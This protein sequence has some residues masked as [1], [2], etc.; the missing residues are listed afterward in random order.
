MGQR[1]DLQALLI[2]TLGSSNVYFQPPPTVQMKYPCIIYKRSDV[3]TKFADNNP[4]SR[5][6]SYQ[7]TVI[8]SDP[9]SL[10]PDKVGMLPKCAFDRFFTADGLNHDVFNLYF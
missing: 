8:D 10:I 3:K 1:S 4:Y 7:V 5:E 6:K 9:D 2:A